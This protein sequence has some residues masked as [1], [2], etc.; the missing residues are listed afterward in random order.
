[1]P[2]QPGILGVDGLREHA[3]GAH[4]GRA[5]VRGGALGLQDAAHV[6]A[7]GQEDLVVVLGEPAAP[8]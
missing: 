8:S 6:V 1:M 2:V 3:D 5:Q 7:E 4:V